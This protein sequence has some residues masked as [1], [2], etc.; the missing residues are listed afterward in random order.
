MIPWG[1]PCWDMDISRDLLRNFEEK[2]PMGQFHTEALIRE[3]QIFIYKIKNFHDFFTL[4][5]MDKVWL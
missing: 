2:T 3:K 5:R 4:K 1:V